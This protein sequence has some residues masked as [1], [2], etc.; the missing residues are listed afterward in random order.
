V[1]SRILLSRILSSRISNFETLLPIP[2]S[3]QG[4]SRVLCN[5]L[6]ATPQCRQEAQSAGQAS[7]I[8]PS[9]HHPRT[10]SRCGLYENLLPPWTIGR[11]P[12]S[13]AVTGT[14]TS[15]EPLLL[16]WRILWVRRDLRLAVSSDLRIEISAASPALKRYGHRSSAGEQENRGCLRPVPTQRQNHDCRTNRNP[17]LWFPIRQ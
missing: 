2:G 9:S 10:R 4:S 1:L 12:A 7:P 11:D 6:S 15:R 14:A 8:N 16:R 3:C 13:V 17:I 5:D